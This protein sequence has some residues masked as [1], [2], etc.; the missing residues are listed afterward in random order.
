MLVTLLVAMTMYQVR[1]YLQK[2]GVNLAHSFGVR[3]HHG[4][5]EQKAVGWSQGSHSQAES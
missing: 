4:R 2:E 1:H 5:Q 3:S